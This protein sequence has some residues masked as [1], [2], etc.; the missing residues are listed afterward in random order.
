M[1]GDP[2]AAA[3]YAARIGGAI[4]KASWIDYVFDLYAALRRPA[5]ASIVDELYTVVR[6]VKTLDLALIRA[7][8]ADLR[9]M[10]SSLGPA[11]KFLIQRLEGLERLVALK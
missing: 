2:A 10:A 6:K 7:Y 1:I 9:G 11:Q 8:L 3:R 4:G 5:P